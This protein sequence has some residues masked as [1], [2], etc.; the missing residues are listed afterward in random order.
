[1]PAPEL[2][3]RMLQR[4][5][6]I[7][8]PGRDGRMRRY[9]RQRGRP[10]GFAMLKR[11]QPEREPVFWGASGWVAGIKFPCL[12]GLA[13]CSCPILKVR[14]VNAYSSVLTMECSV[15]NMWLSFLGFLL[16]Y[17][18]GVNGCKS[19][20]I[21]TDCSKVLPALSVSY[22]LDSVYSVRHG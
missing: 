14:C 17:F 7:A 15:A 10:L 1:M 22:L 21:L 8:A 12:M 13:R 9:S 5:R 16:S 11:I 6:G 20:S 18:V 2:R 3:N 19:C 4:E